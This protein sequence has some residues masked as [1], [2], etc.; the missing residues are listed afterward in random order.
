[1]CQFDRNDNTA[2]LTKTGRTNAGPNKEA[3]QVTL[4]R[5]T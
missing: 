4:L 5:I 1:M 3:R 2:Q